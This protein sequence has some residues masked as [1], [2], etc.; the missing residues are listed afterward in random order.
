MEDILG[1]KVSVGDSVVYITK[2]F[3]SGLLLGKITKIDENKKVQLISS[4][5]D[6][7]IRILP[8]SILVITKILN[9]G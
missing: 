9:R 7:P 2:T 4:W 5:H 8:S 1:N 3:E 6:K